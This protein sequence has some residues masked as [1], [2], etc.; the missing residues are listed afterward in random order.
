M[1]RTWQQS[2][3]DVVGIEKCRRSEHKTK[4]RTQTSMTTDNRRKEE[5]SEAKAEESRESLIPLPKSAVVD[6]AERDISI[7]PSYHSK[8]YIPK[9]E[10]LVSEWNMQEALEAVIRN[11]GAPGIDNITTTEIKEVMQ[12]EWPRI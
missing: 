4:E 2:A 1:A 6:K 12:K 10:S 5:Q 9:I 11:K 7:L 8:I 3:D